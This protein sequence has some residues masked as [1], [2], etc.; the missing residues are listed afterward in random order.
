MNDIVFEFGYN[1]TA[2]TSTQT[3]RVHIF[4]YTLNSPRT[5]ASFYLGLSPMGRSAVAQNR[6]KTLRR[7]EMIG[8]TRNDVVARKRNEP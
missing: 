3:I 6:F 4:F 8:N 2:S 1:I 7:F 5:L